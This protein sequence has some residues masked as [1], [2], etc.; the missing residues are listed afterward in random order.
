MQCTANVIAIDKLCMFFIFISLWLWM[1]I[2]RIICQQLGC[3][4]NYDN[5]EKMEW[6]THLRNKYSL[7]LSVFDRL[8]KSSKWF[9]LKTNDDIFVEDYMSFLM[10]RSCCLGRDV[11]FPR[12]RRWL[13]LWLRLLFEVCFVFQAMSYT[14]TMQLITIYQSLVC[15]LVQKT[16]SSRW[17]LLMENLQKI[18]NSP[19]L[20]FTNLLCCCCGFAPHLHLQ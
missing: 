3:Y 9:D 11:G 5:E 12:Q 2:Q 17:V 19:A 13:P 8:A 18:T 7:G 14:K 4:H 20:S 1:F 10:G 6:P 16:I 15:S